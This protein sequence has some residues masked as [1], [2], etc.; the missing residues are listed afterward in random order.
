MQVLFGKRNP[1]FCSNL[2]FMN[3]LFYSFG[4]WSFIVVAISTPVYISIPIVSIWFGVF[5]IDINSVFIPYLAMYCSIILLICCM[6]NNSGDSYQFWLGWVSNGIYWYSFLKA[7]VTVIAAKITGKIVTF[8]PTPKGVNPEWNEE[9]K[10][11]DSS[12]S[13]L[14]NRSQKREGDLKGTSSCAIRLFEEHPAQ[15]G[16]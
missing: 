9:Y 6:A 2:R 15:R 5:P 4:S 13:P 8:E 11:E 12:S 16:M 3:R 10:R 14:S 1:L 7:I